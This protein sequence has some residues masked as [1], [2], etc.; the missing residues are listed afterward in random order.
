MRKKAIRVFKLAEKADKLGANALIGMNFNYVNFTG[1]I[2]G[3]VIN[4]TAVVV[5]PVSYMA[6]N[7]LK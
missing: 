4:A 1:N 3:V 7:K 6:S 2:I 5:Q